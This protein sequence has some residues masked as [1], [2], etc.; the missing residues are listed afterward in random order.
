MPVTCREAPTPA[1][2]SGTPIPAVFQALPSGGSHSSRR[3]QGFLGTGVGKDSPCK[4]HLRGQHPSTALKWI[5]EAPPP[6]RW[7]L[8]TSRTQELTISKMLS[9]ESFS[10]PGTKSTSQQL[11]HWSYFPFKKISLPRKNKFD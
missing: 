11:I 9:L 5:Q 3:E 1:V 4:M 7:P 6:T 10:Y 2:T 8:V